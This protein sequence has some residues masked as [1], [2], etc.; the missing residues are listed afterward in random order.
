MNYYNY[1]TMVSDHTVYVGSSVNWQPITF[2][3]NGVSNLNIENKREDDKYMN[4][5]LFNITVVDTNRDILL[6]KKVISTSVENA[7]FNS[8]LY[9][10]LKEKELTLDDVTVIVTQLGSVKVKK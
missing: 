7:K 5:I 8:G 9:D 2:K 4:E 6:D 10:I 1:N 3:L